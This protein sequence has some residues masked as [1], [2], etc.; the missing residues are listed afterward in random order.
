MKIT[1]KT[2]MLKCSVGDI[3]LVPPAR[4]Y[5]FSHPEGR[6][7]HLERQAVELALKI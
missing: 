3:M 1:K 2:T 7:P 4:A 5:V 6:L